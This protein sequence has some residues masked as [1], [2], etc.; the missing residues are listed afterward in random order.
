MFIIIV[1]F[2]QNSYIFGMEIIMG[3]GANNQFIAFIFKN[4]IFP[5]LKEIQ[6]IYTWERSF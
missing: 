2:F 4:K 1:V 6:L 3:S 5:E